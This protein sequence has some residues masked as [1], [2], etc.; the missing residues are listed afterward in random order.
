[1]SGFPSELYCLDADEFSDLYQR[2]G[3]DKTEGSASEHKG[4]KLQPK[5]DIVATLVQAELQGH[6]FEFRRRTQNSELW[7]L[8]HNLHGQPCLIAG[9]V[10]QDHARQPEQCAFVIDEKKR[11]IRH[12]CFDSD[13]RD[14]D[15]SK[16]RLALTALG[17]DPDQLLVARTATVSLTGDEL[18]MS[19]GN[20]TRQLERAEEALSAEAARCFKRGPDLV[21]PVMEEKLEQVKGLSRDPHMLRIQPLSIQGVIRHLDKN[22]RC[23]V[24]SDKGYRRAT[25]PEHFA[26]QILDRVKSGEPVPYRQLIAVTQSPTMLAD[27][28]LLDKPGYQDGVLYDVKDEVFPPIPAAPTKE[29]A[30]AALRKFDQVFCK[31]PFV[32]DN[33]EPWDKTSSYGAV[34]AA[35]LSLVGR[36][37][38]PLAPLFTAD[39]TVPGAGKSKAIEAITVSAVGHRPTTC[40]FENEEEF[41]KLIVPL[42]QEGDRSIMIDNVDHALRGARLCSTL[43]SPT[44]SERILG[45]SAKVPLINRAVFFATGN[46]L[47]LEGD[48]TRRALQIKLDPKCEFPE[49]RH[50]D[51]E[52]VTLA[53]EMYPQLVVAA[54][55]AVKAYLLAGKPDVL[56]RPLLGSFEE[57]D[58]LICGTL[59]WCGYA[60]PVETQAYVSGSDPERDRIRELLTTW[61]ATIHEPVTLRHVQSGENYVAVRNLLCANERDWDGNKV[62]WRLNKM[63][64]RIV[65]GMCL[66]SRTSS[67]LR[68]VYWVELTDGQAQ[69]TLDQADSQLTTTED[70]PF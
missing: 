29:D 52:P 63:L 37:A 30:I 13:C 8:Y 48:I 70:A 64:G 2:F 38:F 42:L 22:V 61:A 1:M 26:K 50:F 60:D 20:L 40:S 16:T 33:G 36:N 24:G 49:K 46:N 28:T 35:I 10:H 66:R 4:C 27:G 23:V 47:T 45:K 55:T 19:D 43:T 67:Q 65:N 62:K 15:G 12:T 5:V 14:A 57:W 25:P 11:L 18:V 32:S 41:A 21:M 69:P 9:H 59:V 44:R 53:A 51:F 56:K 17:L 34:L 68:R 58:S 54:L 7:L 6:P 39:A 31:F 3:G